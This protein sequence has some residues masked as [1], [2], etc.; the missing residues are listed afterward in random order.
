MQGEGG[1]DGVNAC[2]MR[3][4]AVMNA[5]QVGAVAMDTG[6]AV[7]AAMNAGRGAVVERVAAAMMWGGHAAREEEREVFP[8]RGTPII[9]S[10]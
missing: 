6:R 7:V 8:G 2:G 10:I 5:G 9:I 4:A 1:G 3:V